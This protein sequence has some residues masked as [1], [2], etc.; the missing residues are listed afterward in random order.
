MRS[1]IQTADRIEESLLDLFSR[2]ALAAR[3]G[4]GIRVR[5]VQERI[6]PLIE[7]L[8]AVAEQKRSPR[9]EET[10]SRVADARRENVRLMQAALGGIRRE[11]DSTSVALGRARRLSPAYGAGAK[12]ASRLNTCT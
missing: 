3:S 2:E 9:V 10:L 4:S 7:A 6:K 1:P 12:V 5:A 11:L 8:C